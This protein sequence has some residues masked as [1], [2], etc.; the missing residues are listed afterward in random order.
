MTGINIRKLRGKMVEKGVSMEKLA[1]AIGVN[2]ATLYRK[3]MNDGKT[4]RVCEANQI[5][6]ELELTSEEAMSIFF[7]S[8]VA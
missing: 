6:R 8:F 7:N 3:F 5:V 4:L 1:E 2:P